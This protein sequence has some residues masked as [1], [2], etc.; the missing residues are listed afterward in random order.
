MM[1]SVVREGTGT[2]AALSGI[3]VAGKTGTAEIIPAQNVN[4]PWFIG[5]APRTNPRIAV[6]ATHRALERDRRRRR[7]A[8]RQGRHGGAAAVS[9]IAQDHVVDGRYRLVSRLGSGGMADVW[10]AEDLQLGR[11]VALKLLHRRFAEDERVRRA[12]PPRGVER[13]RAAAPERRLRLRPG[14]VRRHLLHR[15]GVPRRADAEG[16][17]QARR[18]SSSR[19]GRS[20]WRSRSCAP[21]ASR[22]SAGSSTATSSRTTSS[23]T[24]RTARRSPTSASPGRAR[25]T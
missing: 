12:L 3:D 6:A 21:R 2:A 11:Q 5:F 10:C 19:C 24:P 17:R 7:G 1:A 14:R 23:S 4:Q 13:R 16:P 22:T 18:A 8:D 20:T 15:D 9:G 25:R